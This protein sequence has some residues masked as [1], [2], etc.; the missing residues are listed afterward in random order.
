MDKQK[1]FL[2]I[3]E[4]AQKLTKNL[5]TLYEQVGSYKTARE[6]LEKTREDLSKFIEKTRLLSEGVYET[7]RRINEI[8]AAKIMNG[9]KI[10]FIISVTGFAVL[11]ILG[12]ISILK[13][14]GIL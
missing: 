9:I 7:I 2:D 8:G 14:F 4:T 6:E 11:I 1:E 3:E 10:N 12:I 13:V 5:E